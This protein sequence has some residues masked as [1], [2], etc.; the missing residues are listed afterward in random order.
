[1]F[2]SSAVRVLFF[3]SSRRRHTRYWRDWSSDVCSSDLWGDQPL[4]SA[5]GDWRS[6]D[7]LTGSGWLQVDYSRPFTG[8]SGTATLDRAN[9]WRQSPPSAQRAGTRCCLDARRPTPGHREWQRVDDCGCRRERATQAAF[10]FDSGLLA[11]QVARRKALALHSPRPQ[12]PNHRIV[13]SGGR[14]IQR[15]SPLARLES[16][17]LRVLRKLDR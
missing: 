13:G 15:A 10:N 1:M 9:P 7:R 11:A 8:G 17:S 16:S 3:F 5:V 2:G 14:W 12:K 6:A 4:S